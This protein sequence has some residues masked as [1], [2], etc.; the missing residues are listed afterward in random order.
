[1]KFFNNLF[2]RR[3]RRFGRF[4][5]RT[6][7]A[8]DRRRGGMALGTLVTLAAPFIIRKL[9]ARRSQRVYGGAY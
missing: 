5:R 9:M 8:L 7:Y 3:S 4:S 6:S 1:M 2:G